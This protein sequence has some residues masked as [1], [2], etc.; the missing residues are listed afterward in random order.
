MTLSHGATCNT[1]EVHSMVFVVQQQVLQVL[2]V[3]LTET[4]KAVGVGGHHHLTTGHQISKTPPP[5]SDPYSA[6]V[7][8]KVS[9]AQCS[10]SS[11]IMRVTH[12]VLAPARSSSIMQATHRLLLLLPLHI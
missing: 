4:T 3:L 5:R 2:Q 8:K 7:M 9:A 11:S 6:N 12:N 1:Q 10:S